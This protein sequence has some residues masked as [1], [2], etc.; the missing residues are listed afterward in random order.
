MTGN[1]GWRWSSSVE[2]PLVNSAAP[3]RKADSE[4]PRARFLNGGVG[5]ERLQAMAVKLKKNAADQVHPPVQH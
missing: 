5:R 1:A 3:R 4:G 2:K